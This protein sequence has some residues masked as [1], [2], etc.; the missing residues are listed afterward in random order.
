MDIRHRVFLMFNTPIGFGIRAGLQAQYSSAPP[1]NITT[2]RDDNGDTVFNDRPLGV[3]R[4]SA[5]GADQWNVT[6][7]VNRSFNLGG[8][9]SG[10]PIMM[11]GPGGGGSA[12]RAPSAG[13]P[14]GGLQGA[15]APL[16]AQRGPGG[17]AGEGGGPVVREMIMDGGASRYR[18]DLY[19]QAFNLSQHDEPQRVCR[20]PAVAVLRHRNL[21]RRGAPD[22]NRG[23]HQ[24]LGT[25]T[26][27]QPTYK[28]QRRRDAEKTFESRFALC[29][30]RPC[31]REVVDSVVAGLQ[32]RRRG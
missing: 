16:S 19:A 4:N 22:R 15:P 2:G 20:Q 10:G 11:G 12:E 13:R 3:T 17:G 5:R 21:S 1:Y 7:R 14:S 25:A 30:F 23:I 18:L 27:P 32:P 8:V 28:P 31:G 6:L 26:E 9:A 29:E 24:L